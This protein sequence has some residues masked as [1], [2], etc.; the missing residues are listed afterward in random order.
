MVEQPLDDLPT[1]CRLAEQHGLE[2]DELVALLNKHELRPE[3]AEDLLHLATVEFRSL[4][5][6]GKKTEYTR[7]LERV[8]NSH[9]KPQSK[10]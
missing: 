2:H 9:A 5:R 4:S 3:V 10:S 1:L 8:V 7:E 6:W